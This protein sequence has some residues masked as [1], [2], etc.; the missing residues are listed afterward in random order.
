[1]LVHLMVNS[2]S[3]EKWYGYFATWIK[4]L[5]Y[6]YFC[7]KWCI[8]KQLS[9]LSCNEDLSDRNYLILNTALLF[10]RAQHYHLLIFNL[11]LDYL[12]VPLMLRFNTQ[13]KTLTSSG[14]INISTV[15]L[16]SSVIFYH[17]ELKVVWKVIYQRILLFKNVA[18]FHKTTFNGFVEKLIR[19]RNAFLVISN[20]KDFMKKVNLTNFI[21]S[22]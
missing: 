9:T 20:K 16:S 22:S 21:I 14:V 5:N 1:M 18:L 4:M 3:F 6:I 13:E 8:V 12:D 11:Y 10:Y 7:F 2:F 15:E 19:A 17:F